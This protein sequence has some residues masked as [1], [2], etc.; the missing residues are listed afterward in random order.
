MDV[1]NNDSPILKSILKCR[2]LSKNQIVS[3]SF[4]CPIYGSFLSQGWDLDD[5][6]GYLRPGQ[7]GRYNDSWRNWL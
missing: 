7:P 2:R 4:W 1:E 5:A 6:P 3:R